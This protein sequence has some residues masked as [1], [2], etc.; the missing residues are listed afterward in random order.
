VR[1]TTLLF[2]SVAAA[3]ALTP[4]ATANPPDRDVGAQQDVTIVDQ[5]AFPVLGHID[6]N[7][8]ITTFTDKSDNPIKQI[9]VFPANT[10]TLTNLETSK[11]IRLVATGPSQAKIERDGTLFVQS[12]GHG[13]S[14]PNPVTGEPGIWYSSG[15]LALTFDVE[16]NVIS[17]VSTGRLVN[18]CDQLG[19]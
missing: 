12:L 1:H 2:A 13:F 11:S 4:A 7:E 6:G 16:M 3:L 10:S 17:V 14:F 15:R 18:L 19:S 5:C 8:I 9:R